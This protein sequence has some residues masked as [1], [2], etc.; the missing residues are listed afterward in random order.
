MAGSK[1]R[2]PRPWQR[3]PNDWWYVTLGGKQ[4]FLG[5]KKGEATAAFHLL[6][7]SRGQ[8]QSVGGNLTIRELSDLWLMDCKRSL[9]VATNENYKSYID[10]FCEPCGNVLVR[11]IKQF[12]VSNW[13]SDQDWAQ[14]T[15]HLAISIVKIMVAWGEEVG[16]TSV[17]PI[18]HMKRPPMERRAPITMAEAEGVMSSSRPTIVSALRVLL[19]TGI[20]PGEL[21]SM[22]G[23][24]TN[25]KSRFAIVKGKTGIRKVILSEVAVIVLKPLVQDNPIGPLFL[26]ANGQ[27][28]TVNRL[29]RSVICARRKAKLGEHITP[30]CFRG[31]FATEGL[32]QDVNPALLS[33]LLGHSDPTILMKHYASPDDAMLRDAADRA[34][35]TSGMKPDTRQ[36]P[37]E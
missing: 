19:T 13:I 15:V 26:N 5:K 25:L 20:R 24:N 8:V 32:R 1:G 4:I 35:R 7:A 37:A 23:A 6:M 33:Q 12:H 3:K 30:H 21:C 27:P 29:D 14:S 9:S 16:Y 34:T 22:T 31:L 36:D 28:L 10:S 11:D 2:I 18:R 17:N